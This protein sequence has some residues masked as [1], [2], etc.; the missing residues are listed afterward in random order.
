MSK[1]DQSGGEFLI[2]P[3]DET[4]FIDISD[5]KKRSYITAGLI[6]VPVW[7]DLGTG[8]ASLTPS[9]VRMHSDAAGLTALE[10]YDISGGQVDFTDNTESYIVAD[11]NGG[12]PLPIVI[13]DGSLIN[14]TTV[15]GMY[16][17]FRRG[18]DLR[19]VFWGLAGVGLANK[20]MDR[21][22]AV[23]KF[24]RESG[25][26]LGESGAGIFSVYP[27]YI[28]HG[29]NRLYLDNCFSS[30]DQ[31]ILW[32]HVA[33]V[34][35]TSAVTA[36]N[37]SQYDNGTA[38]ATLS[39]GNYA[40]NYVYRLVSALTKR[41]AIVLGTADYTLNQAQ[42]ARP[43]VALP[44]IPADLMDEY[45]YVGRYI[46]KK[47]DSTST[48]KDSAFERNCTRNAAADHDT[49]IRSVGGTIGDRQHL[50]TA[51]VNKL[52]AIDDLYTNADPTPLT[53]GGIPAGST[54]AD[55]TF[56]DFVDL[57]L[58]PELF[59]TLTAPSSTFTSN[60]EGLREIGEVLAT[61]AFS[62][63]FSRGSIS[64]AYGTSG[65]RSGLPNTY[66]YT[67]TD[68][69]DEVSVSLT[70]TQS[71]SDYTVISGAQ[72]WT[73]KVSFDIGEQPKS[74]KD[75]DYST[76]LA[77]GDTSVVTR[78][79][80][81]VYPYFATTVGI[82]TYTKQTLAAH[83]ATVVTAVVA[84]SGSD[85]QTVQFPAAWGTIGHLEQ[86][87]TLSGLYDV[88]DLATFT[89]SSITKTI[90]GAS[91]TYNQFVHNGGL[92]GARTLRWSI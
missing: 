33:G 21:L 72:S 31:V 42:I 22:S 18:T 45:V 47:G 40:V 20:A 65:Y 90:N 58:Y 17:V 63:A 71:I 35:T 86:Y 52:D 24:Q 30:T 78:T 79:I 12:L 60:P 16:T 6:T 41:V 37:N 77:A 59:P 1:F 76:P 43:P 44:N 89:S 85:K 10:Q 3:N 49:L 87:N 39:D 4:S 48:E 8:S 23:S 46:V 53:V 50:T 56:P 81:G 54:F 19:F 7:T 67:G 57:L 69:T 61:V 68:L 84:E 66:V 51:Q 11:Y 70:D 62:S 83:G 36:F 25:I 92:V 34:W 9:T 26:E 82:T 15:I 13:T 32:Q 64:P 88:I 38:L 75:N 29:A 14:G 55:T 28:W 80:T 27:G 91:V 5:V 2:K 74:S 73:G